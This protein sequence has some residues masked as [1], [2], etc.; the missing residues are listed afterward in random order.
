MFE[1]LPRCGNGLHQ[2]STA[3]NASDLVA[4]ISTLL[5]HNVSH[6]Y[7][8]GEFKIRFHGN[9]ISIKQCS[10]NITLTG[11]LIFLFYLLVKFVYRYFTT[12]LSAFIN[13][14]VELCWIFLIPAASKIQPLSCKAGV[15]LIRQ[16]HIILDHR[17]WEDKNFPLLYFVNTEVVGLASGYVACSRYKN[18]SIRISENM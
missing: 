5:L 3:E 7:L 17:W 8:S 9:I 18:D 14:Q 13:G 11:Y 10:P 6:Y 15:V 1:W 12:L 16:L 2:E 4:E